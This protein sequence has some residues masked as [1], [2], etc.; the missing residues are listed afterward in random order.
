MRYLVIAE[1]KTAIPPE[2][3]LGLYDALKAWKA[4]YIAAGKLEQI[5]SFAGLGG[6]GAGIANVDSLEELDQISA[7]FPFQ[8]FSRVTVYGL[9]DFDKSIESATKAFG[10][11]LGGMAKH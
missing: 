10:A 9:A 2:M 5:W 3:V 4:R 8:P 7:E 6:A 11:M 1:P